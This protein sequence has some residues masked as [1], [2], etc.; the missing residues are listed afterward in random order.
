MYNTGSVGD[1]FLLLFQENRITKFSMMIDCG[2]FK[3]KQKAIIDCVNDIKS[4]IINNTIDLVIVTHEHEDHVSGFNQA[5]QI[6][7]GITFKQVWMSWVEREDDP[8]AIKLLQEKGKKIKTLKKALEK[9][10]ASVKL[11]MRSSSLGVRYSTAMKARSINLKN[12][13]ES[14]KYEDTG[15]LTSLGVRLK[16]ADAMKYVKA[17]SKIRAKS[18]MYKY[19]GQ[20]IKDLDGAKGVN[21]YILGPPYDPDLH[22]IKNDMQSNEMYSLNQKQGLDINSFSFNSLDALFNQEATLRS[23]FESKYQMSESEKKNF[24]RTYYNSRPNKWRQIE[25]DWIDSAG[26]LAIALTDFVNNTSLA[27]AIELTSSGKILLFPADAQSGNWISWHDP[28][29]AK[30]LEQNGGKNANDILQN[31]V[32]YKVGHHGSHNG[33]ASKSGLEKM[34]DENSIVAFMPLIQ[35]KVP[36]QW[37]GSANFPA[38][39]LYRRLIEKTKGVIF[40]TD[41]GLVKERKASNLRKNNFSVSEISKM[42]KA[43]ANPIYHEWRIEA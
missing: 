40:R 26:D 7:N 30:K 42:K 13:L 38:K 39:G 27:F 20:V 43:S 28:Q 1:C 14:I 36:S 6:F 18:K 19:P 32:F 5:R 12:A 37:G 22:G 16:I 33:T 41:V 35:E 17:K 8:L 4:T 21:F 29:V 3:T 9:N 34:R 31:T 2:G 24:N 25:Y 11:D 15:A 10:I 23:P